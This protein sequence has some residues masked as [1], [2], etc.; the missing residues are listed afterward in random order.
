MSK[1]EEHPNAIGLCTGAGGFDYGAETTGWNIRAAFEINPIA[2]WTY[3]KQIAEGSDTWVSGNDI[4]EYDPSK[5]DVD[6]AGLFGGPPCTELS[7]A[8]GEHYDGEPEDLVAWSVIEWV[9][10]LEPAVFAIENVEAMQR[11]YPELMTRYLGELRACGYTVKPVVLDAEEYGVPQKRSRLFVLGVREDFEPPAQWQPEPSRS[12]LAGQTSLTNLGVAK[13]GFETTEEALKD[14][15]EPLPSVK[16]A[17]DP[18]HL[19]PRNDNSRVCPVGSP[20]WIDLIPDGSY[21]LDSG[22]FSGDVSIPLNHVAADHQESTRERFAEMPYGHCGGQTARRLD[23]DEPAPTITVS[24]GT[25]PVHYVG[26]SPGEDGQVSQ[27]RRLTVR[28]CARIQTF[29]DSWAFA[30]TRKEQFAQVGRAVP[31]LLG[32]HIADHLLRVVADPL[33]FGHLYDQHPRQTVTV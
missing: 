30:G 13:D 26:K 19:T 24:N 6:V 3:Q 29:P 1:A 28:E 25:P 31:P 11:N 20:S 4:T 18:V 33:G 21:D 12:P 27:C 17:D 16:P 14:L 23:P 9:D 32:A 22:G 15:P 8:K 7:E 10:K 2:R 5:I